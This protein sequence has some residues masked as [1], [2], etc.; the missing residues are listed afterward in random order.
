MLGVG[1]ERQARNAVECRL[2]GNIPRVGDYSHGM[3]GKPSELQIGHRVY[4]MEYFLTTGRHLIKTF[5]YSPAGV[6]AQRSYH[7]NAGSR[8]GDSPQHDAQPGL[9]GDESL[10]VEREEKISTL[11][12]THS[13][14]GAWVFPFPVHESQV[15]D[16]RIANHIY[17]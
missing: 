11:L 13:P 7:G 4:Y 14:D 9:V 3:C 15:V 12:Q 1:V 8:L 17:F 2:L 10:A 5:L 16:E 6:A